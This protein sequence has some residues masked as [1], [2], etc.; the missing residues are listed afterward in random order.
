[1]LN[2]GTKRTTLVLPLLLFAALY[3]ANAQTVVFNTPSTDVVPAKRVYI[4]ADF[5]GH[6]DSYGKGGFQTYG[7]RLVY[8]VTSRLEVGVNTFYTK[9]CDERQ[10]FEAQPNAKFQ[11]YNNESWG[12]A[13]SVGGM[14]FIPEVKHDGSKTFG[15][16]YGNL[17]KKINATYGP[18]ITGGVYSLVG[19]VSDVGTR[20]GGTVAF[21]QPVHRRVSL[22]GD[23][24]SGKNRF[25]ALFGGVGV[26]VFKRGS[27]YA[28][29]NFGNVGRGNNSLAVTYG[30]TF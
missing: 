4:E 18:K 25:G 12:I 9:C 7:S 8:G 14:M 23:W 5:I 26:T 30:F 17:S 24:Y 1:M 6:L 29:Y 13:S 10:P 3:Q 28:G 20:V 21:E 22:V 15:M 27:L 2:S 11:F 16:I 19:E